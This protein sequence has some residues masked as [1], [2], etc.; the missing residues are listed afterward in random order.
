[1]FDDGTEQA[2]EVVEMA[3]YGKSE[4]PFDRVFAK[5]GPPVITLITCGGD[6]Q[7]DVSSY[8]DNVVAYA[9]PV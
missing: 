5:D 2:Y 8:A 9:V 1:M 3:Q 6:F 7:T 4:L